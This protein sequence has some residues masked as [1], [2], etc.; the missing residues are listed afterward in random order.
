MRTILYFTAYLGLILAVVSPSHAYTYASPQSDPLIA[1]REAY[2]TAV[3]GGDWAAAE[4]AL[5][6]FKPDLDL[7]EAGDD[8]FAGDKG[9]SAAFSDA[10]KNKDADAAK[11]ALTRATIDQ[12]DRRLSGASKNINTYQTASTLVASAQAFYT[13]MAGDLS[14]ATQ[15]TVSSNLQA[16]LDAVGKPGVFGYG[17]QKPDPSALDAAHKA[18]MAALR[19]PSSS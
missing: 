17:A 2:L 10:I 16:A 8:A 6:A 13:A 12:I 9:I 4:K 7:L 11:A 15:K 5:A 19:P 18:I 1:G 14:A 3:N